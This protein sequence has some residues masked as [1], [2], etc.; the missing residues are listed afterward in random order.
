MYPISNTT[1]KLIATVE[2]KLQYIKQPKPPLFK[3][4]ETKLNPW[5]V[6]L[7]TFRDDGVLAP[8][9]TESAKVLTISSKSS[10]FLHLKQLNKIRIKWKANY[11]KIALGL[12]NIAEKGVVLVA[13]PLVDPKDYRHY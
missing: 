2:I 13:T 11:H 1:S 12:Q 6:L 9:K 8:P 3:P 7:C 10:I 5:F 4:F